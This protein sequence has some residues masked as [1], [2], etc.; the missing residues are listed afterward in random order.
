MEHTPIPGQ[1]DAVRF[2]GCQPVATVDYP[3]ELARK[4]QHDTAAHHALA[5]TF[6]YDPRTKALFAQ[7]L[8]NSTGSY[9]F[10]LAEAFAAAK[11]MGPRTLPQGASGPV[12]ASADAPV[13][14]YRVADGAAEIFRSEPSAKKTATF[15]GPAGARAMPCTR[16]GAS[17]GRGCEGVATDGNN[18]P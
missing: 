7:V 13:R 9:R 3:P 4:R 6:C 16:V 17:S 14:L 2:G 8:D 15:A 1:A 12:A 5:E 11:A 18:R 10:N